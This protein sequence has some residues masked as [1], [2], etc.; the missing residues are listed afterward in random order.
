[1]DS[2]R[3]QAFISYSHADERWA[4]WLHR[5]LE[6]YSPPRHLI[7]QQ[8]EVGAVPKRLAP[9]F[10][11][12][13]E[14]ASA[15]DLGD[16]L[17]DALA[18]SN[19]LIVICS[20]A[21]ARS[22]W[23]NEE[24]L[25]YKRLGLAHRVFAII[26]DG[27]PNH[28]ADE[29]FPPALRFQLDRQGQV[30]DQPAEP[31]AA[32]ARTGKDGRRVACLKLIA[33]LLGV[34]FD[35]LQQRE[36]HRRQQRF[37]LV[38]A[39]SFAGMLVAFGLM[40]A[41]ILARNEAQQQRALAHQ[42]AEKA[43][44]TAAFMVDI[45]SVSDPSE[46]R[47]RS[48]TAREILQAGAGQIEQRLT[49]QPQIQA[50]LMET[51]GQV[52][53]SLGL[54]ADAEALL[55]QALARRRH[56]QG[57]NPGELARSHFLLANVLTESASYEQ[58][59]QHYQQ[60]IGLLAQDAD[61][62]LLTD[63]DAA[64]AELYFRTGRYRDARP[65]LEEVVQRRQAQLG[66]RHVRT[67]DAMAELALN[68]FDQGDYSAAIARLSQVLNLQQQVFGDEPHPDIGESLNNLGLILAESG[69]LDKAGGYYEQA[70]AINRRLYGEQHPSVAI[71]LN[72]LA[73]LARKSGDLK[74]A[75]DLFNQALAIHRALHGESHPQVALTLTNL[76]L[77]YQDL[78]RSGDSYTTLQKVLEI[79]RN[80][81][82]AEDP[83]VARTEALL[84]RLEFEQG[85]YSAA[86]KLQS[87]AVNKLA[88]A[89]EPGHPQL[90][91]A[92]LNLAE[93]QIELGR[94]AD[95]DALLQ[96]A[97]AGTQASL[98]ADHW[99]HY[100][101]KSIQGLLL[102]RQGRDGARALLADAAQGLA[103]AQ[104][105]SPAQRRQSQARLDQHDQRTARL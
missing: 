65:L 10:R 3:Y 25:S 58:A 52:Y 70:L 97:I 30:T 84:G 29:C 27:E 60:A 99:Y 39:A 45:F 50:G 57:A 80:S 12:R 74:K 5:R 1:M 11:D 36:L 91:A 8:T 17:T 101:N 73:L 83:Q 46:A 15:S 40:F 23:V 47:G 63:V 31:I 21:A 2:R 53:I 102:S 4:S 37:A 98:S 18:H 78:D 7:G 76:A 59:E 79:Q 95:A 87:Q 67:L 55:Q 28:P 32:D 26:V 69:Q 75:A 72:N 19:A 38:A 34:G 48:I 13:E 64:L 6:S 35:D 16:K 86:L 88:A 22:R 14:L 61:G 33:G 68:Y 62:G 24:I 90:I 42:E 96:L 85:N 105:V 92:R 9:V 77:I 49:E 94:F 82:T 104:G 93:L 81:L 41:A 71:G 20:P 54:F 66:E 51:I 103:S 89:M 56:N 43:R 44:Q 100:W